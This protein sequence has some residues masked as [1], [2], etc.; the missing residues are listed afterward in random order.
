M[1]SATM[2][3]IVF[4]K[5]RPYVISVMTTYAHDEH[6]AADAISHISL[7]AYRYFEDVPAASDYGR[8]ME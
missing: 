1:V 7:I 4:L 2:P 5:N 8:K 6:A 3:G